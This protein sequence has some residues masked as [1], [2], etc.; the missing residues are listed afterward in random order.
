MVIAMSEETIT[1]QSYC[2]PEQLGIE[3]F[4]NENG[5]ISIKQNANFHEEASIVEV[6]PENLKRFIELLQ[7]AHADLVGEQ[8]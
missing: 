7:M 5:G 2:I 6:R 8:E 3:V 4:A 1:T